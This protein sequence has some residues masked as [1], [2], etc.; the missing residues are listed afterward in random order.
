L[1]DLLYCYIVAQDNKEQSND[2]TMEQY[3]YK[4]VLLASRFLLTAL[5]CCGI[6]KIKG[7]E[8]TNDYI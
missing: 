3:N 7:E 1:L 8:G 5:S 6:I 2:N 4:I